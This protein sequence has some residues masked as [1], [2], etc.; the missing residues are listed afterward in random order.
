MIVRIVKMEFEEERVAEFLTIFSRI[1]ERIRTFPGCTHLSLLQD[2]T[3]N[4]VFFTWSHWE[5]G[6]ALQGYR[7]SDMFRQVWS[8]T[9]RLFRTRALAWSLRDCSGLN[10]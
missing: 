9:R 6:D 5:S 1:E 7:N 4:C 8:D 2:E 10:T 3:D